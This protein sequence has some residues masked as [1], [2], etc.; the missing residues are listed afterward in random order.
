MTFKIIN[1]KPRHRSYLSP[2]SSNPGQ[3]PHTRD[4]LPGRSSIIQ[5]R[6]PIPVNRGE[7]IT[8]PL[9][10]DSTDL[11]YKPDKPSF[12]RPDILPEPSPGFA[13][14]ISRTMGYTLT[15]PLN[16]PHTS[17]HC[18]KNP[19]SIHRETLLTVQPHHPK[20]RHRSYLSPQS[21]NPGQETHPWAISLEGSSIIE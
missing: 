4:T 15:N 3:V 21:A 10:R 12:S 9:S 6:T 16:Y 2:Q 7:L 20:T 11:R 5:K 13:P 19:L 14:L 1:T 17:R 18:Q 8:E